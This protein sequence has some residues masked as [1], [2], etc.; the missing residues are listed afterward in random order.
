MVAQIFWFRF[1]LFLYWWRLI[2]YRLRLN[3]RS[4]ILILWWLIL[5]ILWWSVLL[6]ALLV[7]VDRW[8]LYRGETLDILDI[9]ELV[10]LHM[11]QVV[12]P[13]LLVGA[14]LI[15]IYFSPPYYP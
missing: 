13:E 5:L 6:M 7:S 4:C 2:D 3:L 1:F 14:D 10:E 15:Q 9:A 11:L 12:E 8:L